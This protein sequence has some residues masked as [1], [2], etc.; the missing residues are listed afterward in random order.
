MT[1]VTRIFSQIESGNPIAVNERLPLVYDE[2][3]QQA[4]VQ[5]WSATIDSVSKGIKEPEVEHDAASLRSVSEI[6]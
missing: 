3:R 4:V 6:T 2:L 1:N 5:F